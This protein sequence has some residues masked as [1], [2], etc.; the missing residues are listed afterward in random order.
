MAAH[1][2]DTDLLDAQRLAQVTPWSFDHWTKALAAARSAGVQ[3]WQLRSA[4]RGGCTPA[5]IST[6]AKVLAEPS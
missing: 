5:L 1:D 2:S 4:V 6:I 3:D